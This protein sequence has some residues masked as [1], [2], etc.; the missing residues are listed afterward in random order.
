MK[1]NKIKNATESI[2]NSR[3]LC[4]AED[5]RIRLPSQG[6]KKK[7]KKKCERI[8]VDD[9]ITFTG[10]TLLESQKKKRGRKGQ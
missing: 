2:S 8:C 9:G 10:T 7:K 3:R 1:C 5:K 6:T 4:K